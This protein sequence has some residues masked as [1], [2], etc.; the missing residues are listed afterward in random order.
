MY[1][2]K[3][4]QFLS[5]DPIG[6]DGLDDNLRRYVHSR[7]TTHVD[8]DGLQE[9]LP[10]QTQGRGTQLVIPIVVI[11]M[12]THPRPGT[13]SDKILEKTNEIFKQCDVF[14]SKVG[15][16]FPAGDNSRTSFDYRTN[17][18][19]G[20]G[21]TGKTLQEFLAANTDRTDVI[22]IILVDE[23]TNG[24]ALTFGLAFNPDNPNGS[25]IV[26]A[27]NAQ[28]KKKQNDQPGRTLAHECANYMGLPDK[29]RGGNDGDN[30]MSYGKWVGGDLIRGTSLTPEQIRQLRLAIERL[31]RQ[32]ERR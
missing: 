3:I 23:I 17:K 24:G 18:F 19:T 13:L 9:E 6:F 1:D 10:G 11:D 32:R 30:L 15:I 21:W 2:P 14:V 16:V 7:V 28:E 12:T 29:D 22:H 27:V 31:F 4:G 25:A 26:L 8:P 5:E 20:G